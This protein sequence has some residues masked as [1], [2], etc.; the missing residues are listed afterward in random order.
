MKRILVL[1]ILVVLAL[2][3]C[4]PQATETPIPVDLTE[5]PVVTPQ[6]VKTELAEASGVYQNA[7]FGF[8]FSYPADWFG[9]EEYI[10][11]QTLRVEVGSDNVY[12]YGTSPETRVY[13]GTNSYSIIVQYSKNDQGTYWQDVYQA[14][15]PLAEGGSTSDARSLNIKVRNLE[16]GRFTGLEYIATLSETAQT[17]AVYAR[18]VYLVDDQS[19]VISVMGTP[20]NVV[21]NAG[22]DWRAVYQQIDQQNLEL[23][24][25]LVDSI[26]VE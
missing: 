6:P 25:Q 11:E 13:N 19:N 17:E 2:S 15:L 8:G 21:V 16:I 5:L 3:S 14:L 10:T 22:E 7:A 20:N 1:L 23:F 26:T 12:P 4:A 18:Q 9:P 24:Q